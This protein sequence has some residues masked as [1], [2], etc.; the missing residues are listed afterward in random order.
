[1]VIVDKFPEREDIFAPG[2]LV[3]D[4]DGRV[5]GCRGLARSPRAKR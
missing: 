3:R 1:M 2:E 5:I 4:P